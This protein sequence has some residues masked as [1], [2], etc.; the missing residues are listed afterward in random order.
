MLPKS[1]SSQMKITVLARCLRAVLLPAACVVFAMEQTSVAAPAYS[2][3]TLAGLADNPGSSDGTGSAAQ[4]NNP[5]FVALDTAGNV[6][7]ADTDNHTIR[8][9]TPAG[10]VTTVA[11]LAGISG[12]A[13]GT[14]SAARFYRPAGLA[15]ESAGNLYVADSQNH[16]IREVTPAGVVTTLAGLAGNSGSSDG[17]G[18]AARFRIPGD[19]ALDSA[20]NLVVADVFNHTIRKVTPAGVVTTLA[21]LAGNPGSAD[22]TGSAARFNEPTGVAVDS[23]GNTYVAD[24][25]NYTIRKVTPAGVVTTL[26]GLAGSPGSTDGM[27]SAARFFHPNDVALDSAGNLLVADAFNHAIREVTLAGVVT[28]LGGLAGNPGSVD[29]MGSAARFYYPYG[30]AADSTGNVY[31]AD[32]S[33]DTIRKGVPAPFTAEYTINIQAGLNLIANQLDHG[34][35]TLNE[36]LG[37]LGTNG[38]DGL[39]LSKYNNASGTWSVSTYSAANGSWD[40]GDSIA[41]NPGEGAFLQSP[42]NF[43]ITFTGTP[44]VPV[45]PIQ[46]PSGHLYMLSRQTNDVGDYSNIVGTAP[47]DGA[48]VY[49]WNGSSYTTFTFASGVWSPSDPIAAVGEAMWLASCCPPPPPDVPANYTLNIHA[50]LNLIANQ[51]DHGSNTLDE[52]LGNLGTNGQDGLVLSKYNN[53][54]GTWSISTYSVA[55]G[56]WDNGNSIMLNPGEGA[57]LQSP[58]NFSIT[59]TGTPHVPVLPI[60]VPGGHLYL[61]SRQTNDVGDYSNILGTSPADGATAYKLAGSGY[62]TFTFASGVWSPSDPIAA[63]G[64]AMWL[65]S[66]CLPPPPP[67]PASYTLNVQGGLNLIA[68]QLDHGSN[69]LAEIM[70]NVP[71]GTE[72]F[73]YDTNGTWI[74]SIYSASLGG[75][76]P[77]NTTLIPGEGAVLQSPTSFSIRFTGTPHVPVL[78]LTIPGGAC[79]LLSRQTNDI[80]TFDNIVGTAPADGAT[81]YK[82]NGSGYGTNIFSSGV[83][84]PADPTAGVGEAVWIAPSGGGG[85]TT[86]PTNSFVIYKGLLHASVGSATLTVASNRL[87]IGNLGS[88]G[89]DGVAIAL[90]SMVDWEAKWLDLEENGP[91][92]IGAYLQESLIGSAGTVTNGILGT[93]TTTKM[94]TS[95]YLITVDFSPM[96]VSNFTVAVYNGTNL[97]GQVPGVGNG[98]AMAIPEWTVSV[99]IYLRPFRIIGDGSLAGVSIDPTGAALT[100]TGNNFAFI[101]DE[102][103]PAGIVPSGFQ[104]QASE[105]PSLTIT[106]ESQTV[107]YAGLSHTSLGNATLTAQ[108]NRLTI[109]NIGSSGQDGVELALPN[110]AGWEAHWQP[111]DPADALPIGAYIQSQIF[112]TAGS[113]S[114]GLLGSW[115]MTKMGTSN[116]VVTADYSPIG[117]STVTLKVYNGTNLVTTMTGQ[118][119]TLGTINGCV[120]DDH[121]GNP[122]PT[123]PN[124]L[125]GPFGGGL[126]MFGPKSITLPGGATVTGDRF[127]ILPE[128]GATVSSLSAVKLNA[129]SIAEIIITEEHHYVSFAALLNES[130][131]DATLTVQ[132]NQLTMS[133]IGS[134]GQD[135]VSIAMPVVTRFDMHWQESNPTN[136]PPSGAFMDLSSSGTVAGQPAHPIG[137]LRLVQAGTN[138]I[139]TADFSSIN[140]TSETVRLYR[141]GVLVA[142]ATAQTGMVATIYPRSKGHFSRHIRWDDGPVFVIDWVFGLATASL[143]G[144]PTLE[145]DL[146]EITPENPLAVSVVSE[147]SLRAKDISSL[148][149]LDESVPVRFQGS[150]NSVLGNA[151]LTAQSNRLTIAN[152]RSSGQDGVEIEIPNNPSSGAIH[153]LPLDP[154]NAAPVGAYL[155]EQII[156]TFGSVTNGVLGT[157]TTTKAATSNYVMTVDFTPIGVSNLLLQGYNGTVLVGQ[158]NLNGGPL[159]SVPICCP[160]PPGPPPGDFDWHCCPWVFN[161]TSLNALFMSSAIDTLA[162]TPQGISGLVLSAVRITASGIPSITITNET[163]TTTYGGVDHTALGDASLGLQSNHLTVGNIG[164]SGQDGVSI[165]I[166]GSVT[167]WGAQWLNFDADGSLATNASLTLQVIGTANG[168]TNGVLGTLV[169]T[170]LGTSNYV[171]SA[172]F[173]PI[174]VINLTV[175]VYNRANLAGQATGV[176]N[177]PVFRYNGPDMDLVLSCCPLKLRPSLGY[178]GNVELNAGPN[179]AGDSVEI[180]P[181]GMTAATIGS[182]LV[183]RASEIPSLTVTY[184]TV[185]PLVLDGTFTR[186]NLTLQWFGTGNLQGSSNLKTWTDLTN[187]VSPY[188]APT[189]LSNQFYRIK[190]PMGD[191]SF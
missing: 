96:G 38:Q 64:E 88:S 166:P 57:F 104:I 105:I 68:N 191:R 82:W 42:T 93:L 58:S 162:M 84:A 133:N 43:S 103:P 175:N 110:V 154:S 63:V 140:S 129:S 62:T 23:A 155:K 44:H 49:K 30:V 13:D 151:T 152:I 69:R 60:Q 92:P 59:F 176:P 139:V 170:K 164:S 109:A 127:V 161:H 126:T 159:F 153:W 160:A 83:W 36:V 47:A 156:G 56:S 131:G 10:V 100:A 1:K 119:G 95:N 179:F 128:G 147:V 53:A 113:V 25:Y 81:V 135:G 14:G 122:V 12:G 174:G 40:N 172:D 97:A 7:V 120:D 15:V 46:V 19:V 39:V 74:S 86:V 66:C 184:E 87:D 108:S 8:K 72:L 35:N 121:H 27:G 26:A 79:Y 34:S 157:L 167:N 9:V 17:T 181:Q 150:V 138:L 106:N 124:G 37:N 183:V 29:G 168:V 54:S 165:A 173:S 50:G 117:S 67:I 148:D 177:G 33:N 171:T 31:V 48:T 71:E 61:L 102:A 80:G 134:S 77:N 94:G 137:G 2:F 112:G 158:T 41:L 114:N 180:I 91:L 163:M 123:G 190:Q 115:L 111:L 73:K 116:Y 186:T 90:P 142:Q 145:A 107:T 55:N 130:L 70:S 185:F 85:P 187:E 4:F 118:S 22:G 51:L 28:T 182:L 141:Q 89:Q 149:I 132:S 144:G 45:L 75:W 99:H 78:P 125:P 178:T 188:V 101:P 146:L 3:T 16:T 189:G 136:I 21:G 65:A 32:S 20:G 98:V 169:M 143:N 5:Y 52:V 76:F 18:S 11:G 24:F 6:Y